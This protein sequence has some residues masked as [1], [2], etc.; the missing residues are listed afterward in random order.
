[1][2]GMATFL[3]YMNAA[4]RRAVYEPLEDGSGGVYA[5]IPGFEGLWASGP[6][7]EDARTDL[8]DALDG[9]L[10]VN[11]FASQLELPDVGVRFGIDKT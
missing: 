5:H 8:Y 1:M 3:E 2:E 10:T 11:H 6:T 4:M 9:W 7:V